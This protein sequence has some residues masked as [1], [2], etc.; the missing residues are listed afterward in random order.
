MTALSRYFKQQ[1]PLEEN[2]RLGRSSSE[3]QAQRFFPWD[4]ALRWLLPRG[5]VLHWCHRLYVFAVYLSE[6]SLQPKLRLASSTEHLQ[7][8]CAQWAVWAWTCLP[9]LGAC[10]WVRAAGTWFTCI[11]PALRPNQRLE[12][13]RWPRDS[14][15]ICLTSLKQIVNVNPDS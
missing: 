14:L 13:G 12:V 3:E 1:V 15:Q 6:T 11:N 10:P 2:K 7:C 4:C 9:G 5:S 8:I